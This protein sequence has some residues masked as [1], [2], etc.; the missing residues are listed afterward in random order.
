[1]KK[2]WEWHFGSTPLVIWDMIYFMRHPHLKTCLLHDCCGRIPSQAQILIDIVPSIHTSTS[3]IE[4]KV[5]KFYLHVILL[6]RPYFLRCKACQLGSQSL[7]SLFV[8]ARLA[9]KSWLKVL[10][11]DLMWEKNIVRWLI[12]HRYE[13]LN[14]L[15][16]KFFISKK[17]L[18]ETSRI[19]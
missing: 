1:M 15:G 18:W 2:K 9:Y 4:T 14:R 8:L 7:I 12:S 5:A 17:I 11:A 13:L 16:E 6:A 10:L 3:N 19:L